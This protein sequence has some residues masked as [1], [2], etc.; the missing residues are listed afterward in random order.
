MRR[1]FPKLNFQ[2]V[3]VSSVSW[4]SVIYQLEVLR[5]TRSALTSALTNLLAQYPWI[6]FFPPK[7]YRTCMNSLIEQILVIFHQ[8]KTSPF[9]ATTITLHILNDQ[10]LK[11]IFRS[12]SIY[13]G[14][15]VLDFFFFLVTF[16]VKEKIDS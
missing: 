8:L 11:H 7:E 5:T 6:L 15:M 12:P 13:L 14:F 3:A 4:L 2:S 9:K 1:Y 16:N 10:V